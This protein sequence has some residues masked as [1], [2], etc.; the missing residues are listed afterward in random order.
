MFRGKRHN[1]RSDA[2]AV[3]VEFS[4]AFLILFC[5]I[6]FFIDIALTYYRFN[7]LV[8]GTQRVSRR[9]AVDVG[10]NTAPTALTSSFQGEL[11]D[12][13]SALGIPGGDI[14]VQAANIEVTGCGTPQVRCFLHVE[15]ASWHSFSIISRLLGGV[16]NFETDAKTLI[17]DPCFQC[18]SVCS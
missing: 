1:R 12:Y 18:A 13:F 3:F 5:L 6:G 17:E 7:I 16:V 4:I 8:F 15:G 9:I 10:P 11:R 2:G 14:H